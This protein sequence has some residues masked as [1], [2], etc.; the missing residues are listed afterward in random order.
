MCIN[1]KA[2]IFDKYIYKNNFADVC[3]EDDEESDIQNM[4]EENKKKQNYLSNWIDY[5]GQVPNLSSDEESDEIEFPHYYFDIAQG[6]DKSIEEYNERMK[7]IDVIDMYDDDEPLK[8]FVGSFAKSLLLSQMNLENLEV[9]NSNLNK[10]YFYN[11]PNLV[12]ISI[13]KSDNGRYEKIEGCLYTKRMKKLIVAERNIKC[14][15]I[16]AKC[17]IIT[18]YALSFESLEKVD[19]ERNSEIQE[20]SFFA[21]SKSNIK[22]LTVPDDVKVIDYCAFYECSKLESVTLPSSLNYLDFFTFSYSNLFEITI[23]N[24]VLTIDYGCFYRCHNL[25]KVKFQENSKMIEI[26]NL[27]FAYTNIETISI[28]KSV[29]LISTDS[30]GGCKNLKSVTFD[31]KSKLRNLEWNPSLRTL[32]SKYNRPNSNDQSYK[33][34]F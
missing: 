15:V 13:P 10:F 20:I 32:V 7:I 22:S 26:D 30:F 2:L 19:F 31:N 3:Y 6:P 4:I 17:K 5:S 9:F 18:N 21:F 27:A 34:G 14:A 12:N 16:N 29:C 33:N 1:L 28:P 8:N 24:S 25:T 11:T 23:P